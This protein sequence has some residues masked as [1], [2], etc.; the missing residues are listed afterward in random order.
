MESAERPR[1]HHINV[2]RTA[3]FYTLGA[4]PRE[5]RSIWFL[6]HGYSQLGVD[7]IQYFRPLLDG[8]TLLVAPEALMRFYLDSDA[9][10][11]GKQSRVGA[12]WM[13]REDRLNDIQDYVR[14]LDSVYEEILGTADRSRVQFNILGFS[15]GVATVARWVVA[16]R[17]V[18]DSVIAWGGT[19]PPDLDLDM[20]K[21]RLD[22]A[23]LYIVI[24]TADEYVPPGLLE[25]EERRLESGDIEYELIRFDGG[26][27]IS[28]TVL[29]QLTERLNQG[30]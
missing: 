6:C 17:Y 19:L 7:F 15:Q 16:S 26:H 8:A 29:A 18:P 23:S 25:R 28:R 10:G 2:T 24:G 4:S 30:I 13:T 21:R 22:Q 12:T 5:A 9:A 27:H 20:L 1:E 3:R 14:Y 11:K